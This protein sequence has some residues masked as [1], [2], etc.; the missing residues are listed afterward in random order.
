MK[1]LFYIVLTI[2]VFCCKKK[3][4]SI[5]EIVKYYPS[6]DFFQTNSLVEVDL[7]TPKL[8]FKEITHLVNDIHINDSIPYILLKHSDTLIK[9][10]PLRYD[11]GYRSEKNIIRIIETLSTNLVNTQ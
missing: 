6:K 2:S 1:K 8:K 4:S 7:D 5:N 3:Q 10:M 11:W 9:I